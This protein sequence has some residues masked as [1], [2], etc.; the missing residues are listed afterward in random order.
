MAKTKSEF[1]EG[2]FYTITNYIFWFFLGNLY[3]LL[4]NIPLVFILLTV[5]SNGTNPLP[6]GLSVIAFICCIPIGPAATA[7]FS[8]MGKLVR[9]KDIN[10]TNDFFKAYKANFIQSLF[11][12][13]LEM[14]LIIILFIDTRFFISQNFP[15]ILTIIMYVF[16]VFIFMMGLYILPILSRFYMK[17]S[18]II[19][20]S[21]YYAFRKINVTFLNLASF[22]VVGFIFFK[23]T[24][25][26]LV[27]I[28]SIVC[29]L[30]MYYEQKILL[31][32]EEKLQVNSGTVHQESNPS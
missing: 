21:S 10:I 7:L 17:S 12:W 4:M 2:P 6:E 32:I 31:E 3:F 9:E 8:V 20:L 30:I 22:L 19:K 25:F 14:V 1:G 5:L 16:I 29:F 15:P 11:L 26:I 27:F 13:T 23:V 28:S 24:T 18:N